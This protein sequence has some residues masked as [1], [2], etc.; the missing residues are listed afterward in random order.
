MQISDNDKKTMIRTARSNG[1]VG[2]N[3]ILPKFISEFEG[4]KEHLV[5]DFGCGKDAIH[6][7]MLRKK[8]FEYA[9]GIDLHP[10][11]D[12]NLEANNGSLPWYL[13]Y[14]SNVLNV[15]PTRTTLNCTICKLSDYAKQGVAYLSYPKT[16]RKLKLTDSQMEEILSPFFKAVYKFKIR[17][18]TIYKCVGNNCQKK[19]EERL[20]VDS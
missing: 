14:A 15:Q 3:A 12:S 10:L 9:Y 7:Q 4:A 18:T 16:P 19:L 8:G 20:T 13:V 5:L 17:G 6:V 11:T 1:A 2:K